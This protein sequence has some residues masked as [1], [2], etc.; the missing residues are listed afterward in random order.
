[1]ILFRGSRLGR[2]WGEYLLFH[3]L[4]SFP[5]VLQYLSINE[6]VTAFFKCYET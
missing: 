2:I 5:I 3:L 4:I 6:F 1:M